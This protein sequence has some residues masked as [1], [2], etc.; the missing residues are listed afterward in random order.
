M[1]PAALLARGGEDIPQSRPEPERAISDSKPRSQCKAALLQAAEQVAPALRVLSEPVHD[2]Q[3]IFLAI[4]VSAD[5]HQHTLAIAV[6]TWCE[7]DPVRPNVDVALARQVTLAP[8]LILVP[9]R[10][11]QARDCLS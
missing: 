3:N 11:L 1:D 2:P 5:N 4:L 9:P 8:G 6:E 7:V 10:R